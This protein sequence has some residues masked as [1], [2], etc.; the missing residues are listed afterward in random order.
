M[1]AQRTAGQ[2]LCSP[3]IPILGQPQVCLWFIEMAQGSTGCPEKHPH[4]AK[5]P[6]T[7]FPSRHLLPDFVPNPPQLREQ[8]CK[9]HH[10]HDIDLIPRT[11]RKRRNTDPCSPAPKRAQYNNAQNR[12]LRATIDQIKH[13]PVD[14]NPKDAFT[15][16]I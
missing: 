7:G 12:S 14:P 6:P 3:K 9:L 5:R 8:L 16:K 15:S 2:A 11:L 13:G 4:L 10:Y 1:D